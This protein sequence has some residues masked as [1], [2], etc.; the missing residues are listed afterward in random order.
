MAFINNHVF[1]S[2]PYGFLDQLRWTGQ[3]MEGCFMPSTCFNLSELIIPAFDARAKTLEIVVHIHPGQGRILDYLVK[4][5]RF[6]F[7]DR[8][9]ITRW[10]LCWGIHTLLGP[11]PSFFALVEA[12]MNILQ[13]ERFQRQKD[14]LAESVQKYLASGEKEC[15]K[16]LVSLS[17]EEYSRIPNEYW[18]LQWISTL[19]IAIEMLR[20][21]GVSFKATD[22]S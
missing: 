15:A 22:G 10:C 6:P 20:Q 18:R 21:N 19:S 14:C 2:N 1:D 3:A 17:F 9:D 13:D 7:R 11:I 12:K 4:C 8:V 5:D 16:R